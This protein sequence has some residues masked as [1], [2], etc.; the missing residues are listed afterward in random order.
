MIDRLKQVAGRLGPHTPGWILLI[1]GVG[2]LNLTLLI[3]A[4][5]ESRQLAWQ[6]QVMQLQ[7]DRLK[8]QQQRYEQFQQA[9]GHEDP[10]LL[11]QLAYWHLNMM[12]VG[13]TPVRVRGTIPGTGDP[14]LV[15]SGLH[16]STIRLDHGPQMRIETWLHTPLPQLGVDYKPYQSIRSRLVRITTGSMRI[17]CVAAGLIFLVGGLVPP[18]RRQ[19]IAR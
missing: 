6:R 9:L 5:L 1:C 17:G 15:L 13:L 12:P 18:S 7:V 11:Q 14:Y 8:R 19:I 4:W 3:P 16:D 2:L 10:V